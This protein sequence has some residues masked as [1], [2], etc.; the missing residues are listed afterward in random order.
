MFKDLVDGEDVA[1]LIVYDETSFR[2]APNLIP[3]AVWAVMQ[4]TS[5]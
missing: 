5:E 4:V 2:Q 3:T 1:V